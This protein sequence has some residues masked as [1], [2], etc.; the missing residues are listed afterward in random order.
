M[1]G[2]FS[3]VIGLAMIAIGAVMI[4]RWRTLPAGLYEEALS[5]AN[6]ARS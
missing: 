4:Y 5:A 1:I 3:V 2:I 6:L